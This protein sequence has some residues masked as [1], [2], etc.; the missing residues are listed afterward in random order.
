MTFPAAEAD[1]LAACLREHAGHL[2][3]HLEDEP[4][5]EHLHEIAQALVTYDAL[6]EAA[7][8]DSERLWSAAYALHGIASR[9]ADDCVTAPE[10]SDDHAALRQAVEA[11][12][13][14]NDRIRD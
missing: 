5:G 8:A 4:E 14:A 1:A 11:F 12:E 3:G 7:V 6:R 9:C 13:A 2:A 10:F